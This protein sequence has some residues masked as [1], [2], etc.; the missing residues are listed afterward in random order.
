VLA[1]AVLLGRAVAQG[2]PVDR[3]PLDLAERALDLLGHQ[4]RE[5]VGDVEEERRQHVGPPAVTLGAQRG[6]MDQLTHCRGSE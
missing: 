4:V 5:R 3:D 6:E 2:R 1:Q